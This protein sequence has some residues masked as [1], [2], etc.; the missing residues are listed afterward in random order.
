MKEK[1]GCRGMHNSHDI[2]KIAQN[3]RAARS[4]SSNRMPGYY[5]EIKAPKWMGRQGEE[6]IGIAEFRAR[7]HP[8][9]H[10]HITYKNKHG[11][12][13]F[14]GCYQIRSEQVLNSKKAERVR[15]GVIL[16][17]LKIADL[18]DIRGD[19]GECRETSGRG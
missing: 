10:V 5:Y 15:G 19:T 12:Q 4:G 7:S 11:D 14:P 8:Y 1:K 18:T 2:S 3:I 9:L 17:L 6:T 13:P 16:K